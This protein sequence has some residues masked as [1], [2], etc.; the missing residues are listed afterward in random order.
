[1]E[2][3][4]LVE[5]SLWRQGG[6]LLRTHAREKCRVFDRIEQITVSDE[7]GEG[8]RAIRMA[9]LTHASGLNQH[10]KW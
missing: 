5:P 6:T 8:A 9:E 1:M 2:M 4:Q 10:Y 3:A 7:I